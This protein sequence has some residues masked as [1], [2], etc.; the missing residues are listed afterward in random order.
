MITL[1]ATLIMAGSIAAACAAPAG[2]SASSAVSPPA[3]QA[4]TP[5]PALTMAP[6]TP[7]PTMAPDTPAPTTFVGLWRPADP[8]DV[9]LVDELDR[10]WTDNDLAGFNAL[11]A[12]PA[13]LLLSWETGPFAR[14]YIY[15]QVK[16]TMNVYE[17]VG[18]VTTEV[19][20][21]PGLLPFVAEGGRY[22]HYV[23]SIHQALFD[24]VLEVSAEGTVVRHYVDGYVDAATRR[25]TGFP[26]FATFA[27]SPSPG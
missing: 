13:W 22:L 4:P 19:G 5:S 16:T 24:C 12:D 2:P 18:P 17:R 23:A 27:P 21:V 15:G 11:Y 6:D 9:E 14:N 3:T 1:R 25:E 10:I 8:A 20:S 7:E 26:A